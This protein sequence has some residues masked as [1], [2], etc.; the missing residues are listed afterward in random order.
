[1]SSTGGASA[2]G[3]TSSSG[4]ASAGGTTSS[5]GGASAGGTTSSS[6]G[7]SA[8][9]TTSSSGG[10]ATG[11]TGGAIGSGG[12]PASGGDGGVSDAGSVVCTGADSF[13]AL[14]PKNCSTSADCGLVRHER[15]CCGTE[16]LLGIN[17][18]SIKSFDSAETEC[19]ATAPRCACAPEGVFAEDGTEVALGDEALIGAICDGG[20]CHSVYSGRTYSC[21]DR[22]CTDQQYCLGTPFTCPF[23]PTGC[24][25]CGCLTP[26]VGCTCTTSN[27]EDFVLC[28]T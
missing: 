25:S 3:T 6:G 16:L 18:G 17:I 22:T 12:V 21:G 10:A 19:D 27:G 26:A 11:G 1:V 4:G 14:A 24:S 15:D 2:G 8:G 28:P 13:V 5:S 9:G 20:T 23:L 7:A